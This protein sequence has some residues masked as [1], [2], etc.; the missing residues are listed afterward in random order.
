[1]KWGTKGFG[2]VALTVVTLVCVTLFV[3][4]GVLNVSASSGDTNTEPGITTIL[5][6]FGL[7]SPG[8]TAKVSDP[9]ALRINTDIEFGTAFPGQTHQGEFTVLLNDID[10][11]GLSRVEYH[12]TPSGVNGYLDLTPYLTVVRDPAE[13]DT[14]SDNVASA[15][16]DSSLGDTSDRWLVTLSLPKNVVLGDYWTMITVMVDQTYP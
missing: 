12:L 5:K 8:L 16:L 9:N 6:W 10:G 2:L 3:A 11:G 14:E 1:M 4:Y 7:Q 13:T 15:G